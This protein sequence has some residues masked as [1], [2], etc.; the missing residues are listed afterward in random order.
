MIWVGQFGVEQG[1]AKEHAPWV[2]A[3]PD[4]SRSEDPSDI[5]VI[6]EPALPGSEEF[7]EDLKNAIG[8]NFHK[9]KVS[10]T[11]GLLRAMEMAHEN[12]RE[13]NRKSIKDHRVAAGVSCL[14]IY[15]HD[16]YLAQVA[17]ASAVL[18]RAGSV[19]PVAPRI[20][21]ANEP[22]GLFDE[23]RPDFWRF[24]LEEDDRILVLTPGLAEKLTEA[25]L[26][27]ALA[28]P[29]DE[30]LPELYRKARGIDNCAAL[31]VAAMPD[32]DETPAA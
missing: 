32:P 6:V 3:F 14:A 16:A 4:P 26:S 18:Y 13:W 24:E 21:D 9:R 28:L 11:G 1:E 8:D 27:E 7:C 30:A 25:D 2:G 22:L 23:F 17:P 15:Q 31:L 5:Y 10:L 12:L 20:P 19:F 29:A